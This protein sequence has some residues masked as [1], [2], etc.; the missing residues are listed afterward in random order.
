MLKTSTAST[1]GAVAAAPASSCAAAIPANSAQ[2]PA[3]VATQPKIQIP[4]A[5]RIT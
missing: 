3:V 1:L 4:L 2:A 5:D